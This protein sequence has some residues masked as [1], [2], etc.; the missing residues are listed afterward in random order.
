MILTD[1]ATQRRNLVAP[2][3]ETQP[4]ISEPACLEVD[5]ETFSRNFDTR[6]FDF[7]HRLANNPLF[8]R[9]A[10][11]D[12]TRELAKDPANLYYDAGDVRIGQ[13]WNEVPRSKLTPTELLEQMETADGWILLKRAEKVP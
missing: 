3:R 5:R 6:D 12:L 13:R 8:D 10:L 9:D 7:S 1:S 11:L 2:P 4:R